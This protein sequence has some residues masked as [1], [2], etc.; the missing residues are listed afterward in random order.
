MPPESWGRLQNRHHSSIRDQ[1]TTAMFKMNEATWD[2][3][4]RVALGVFCIWL[5][6]ISG[7]LV[8]GAAVVASMVGVIML[9]TGLVGFCPL[10]RVFGLS[11][12][13]R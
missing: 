2:R 1:E 10:Y 6:F 8:G 12:C 11:T 5:G 13:S 4:G 9:L 7:A 3:A